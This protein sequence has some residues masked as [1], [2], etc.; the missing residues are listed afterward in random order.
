M[1]TKG[2]PSAL[3]V[4]M[5]IGAATVESSM[6]ITQKIKS[7]S[8]FQPSNPISGNIPEGT[9]NT[10]LKER[11]Y[12]YVHCSVIYNCQDMEAAQ[13]SIRIWA[14]KTIMVLLHNGIPVRHR[15]EENLTSSQVEGV[16]RYTLPPCTTKRKT[17]K[18]LKTKNNQNCWNIELYGSPTTKEWKKD[19]HSDW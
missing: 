7:W 11:K 19:I 4:E 8:A 16:G 6:E 15:R 9:E 1:W 14:D 18:N 5:Q 13:V 12:L 2:N 10:N 17:T 3:L